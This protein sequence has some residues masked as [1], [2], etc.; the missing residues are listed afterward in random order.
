MA[1]SR[2]F[3]ERLYPDLRCFGCGPA[4]DKGLRINSFPT[5]DQSMVADWIAGPRTNASE[6][7]EARPRRRPRRLPNPMP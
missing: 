1:D 4:N 5:S 2:S 6:A 3:Q 7:S